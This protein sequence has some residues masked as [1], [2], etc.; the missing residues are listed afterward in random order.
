MEEFTKNFKTRHKEFRT[1]DLTGTKR[2]NKIKIPDQV[3][4]NNISDWAMNP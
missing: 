4:D 1:V 2:F 3:C